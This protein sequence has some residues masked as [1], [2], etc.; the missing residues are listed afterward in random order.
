MIR[1]SKPT[2]VTTSTLK[3]SS[4]FCQMSTKKPTQQENSVAGLINSLIFTPHFFDLYLKK[5]GSI[6]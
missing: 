3:Q 6:S 4:Y 5:L 2:K 1:T